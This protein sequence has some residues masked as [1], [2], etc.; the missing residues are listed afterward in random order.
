MATQR[1][2]SEATRS[3]VLQAAVRVLV[4]RG[5]A[6]ASTTRIVEEAGV[7]RGAMLHHFPSKAVLMQHVLEHVLRERERAFHDAL[8]KASQP[9]SV[10]D[11]MDA[12]WSSVGVEEAFVPWLELMVAARTEPHLSSV[13]TDA[14]DEIHRVIRVN[15][16]QLFDTADRPELHH[17]PTLGISVLHGLAMRNLIRD[18]PQTT[19]TVLAMVK[20]IAEQLLIRGNPEG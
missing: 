14:A 19:Q 2:R 12:F 5:Y 7:S 20:G 15:F 10:S 17:I 11:V 6:A 16:E 4:Q 3:R 13:L 18:D 9:V 8:A 1:E